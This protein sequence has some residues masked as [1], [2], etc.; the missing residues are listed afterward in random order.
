[1]AMIK[2]YSG[3]RIIHLNEDMFWYGGPQSRVNPG[4]LRNLP[5]VRAL[6]AKKGHIE[7]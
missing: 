6:V 5:K 4:P 7:A 2:R 1:M 3:T